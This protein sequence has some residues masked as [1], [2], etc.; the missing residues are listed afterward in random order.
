MRART[1]LPAAAF[2]AALAAVFLTIL[3]LS[4]LAGPFLETG[5]AAPLTWSSL[6]GPAG[7]PALGIA[8]SPTYA[9]DRL[10]LAGGGFDLGRASWAGRGLFRSDDGG[11]TWPSRSG[12]QNG[13]LLDVAFSPAWAT[14]HF[15]LAGYWFGLWSTTDGGATWQQI[16][17]METGG[18]SLVGAVAVSPPTG[19]KRTLLAGSSYGG[20]FRS[21]DNGATWAFTGGP[22]SVRRVAFHP[23]LP[24][25][26]LAATSN[27]LWR[28][29]NAGLTWTAVTTPTQA[30]DI[31][32]R[33]DNGEA[34]ATFSDRLWRSGDGGLTWQRFTSLEARFL[35][36]VAV[37]PEGSGL[38]ASVGSTIFRYDVASSSFVTL[39]AN[40]GG[41]TILRLAISPNYAA[42]GTLFAG[43]PDG[44]WIS[45]DRGDTFVRSPGFYTL[46]VSHLAPS[47]SY[48][49][50]G[51]LFV[52]TEQ[53]V[54]RRTGGAWRPATGGLTGLLA[55]GVT[56]LAI[57][58]DYDNDGTLFASRPT[59][60][61]IGGALY[62]S[63]D[64][65]D[66]WRWIT[67]KAYIGG[68][69]VSPAFA[70]DHRAYMLGESRVFTSTDAGETWTIAP[71]WIYTYTAR[72]LDI[73]PNFAANRTLYAVGSQVY[74]SLDAGDT[75]APA[76]SPPPLQ[77]T[78]AP[79]WQPGHLAVAPDDTLLLAIYRYETAAP[80]G[81]HDQLWRSD[82]GGDVWAQV[83]AVPDLPIAAVTFDASYPAHP[84]I[85]LATFDDNLV[86]DHFLA[87]DL[88][89]SPDDGASW[90]N[91]GPPP[92]G[93]AIKELVAPAGTNDTLLAGAVGV[94][95][96]T[97]GELPTATPDPCR[98]LLRNRSFEYE[99][100]WRIPRTA[101]PAARTMDKASHAYWS[102]RSGITTPADNRRSYSDFSQD[103][104]LPNLPT[105]KL[106]F[107]RWPQGAPGGG[108]QAAALAALQSVQTEEQF[109]QALEAAGGDLQYVLVIAPP[110]GTVRFAYA[111]LA[112]NRAW[113]AEEFD[114]SSYRGQRVRIQFGTYNDGLGA[115]AAQYF[116]NM[117]LRACSG[118]PTPRLWLPDIRSQGPGSIPPV[119]N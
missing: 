109:Y 10:V 110:G 114:L 92:D 118:P 22:S 96:V 59:G 71:V 67:T 60:A 14:D 40:L 29:A 73:S 79:Q 26:A 19:A 6:D 76:T 69:V 87:P 54:W 119:R 57:S 100:D 31:A 30:F 12:P 103:V 88:F 98:E 16:S 37:S 13:A 47:A 74:R 1:T 107:Q 75:W 102:M 33:A 82:D 106:S 3:S 91:V 111:G 117:S 21:A 53:G 11:L 32:F 68:I 89:R 9:Q 52:A 64:R 38:F 4:A 81:R 49:T 65:G 46:T 95:Q 90:Q 61:S 94:W 42:D 7:G 15:A 62:K 70:T 34:Y 44:V 50:G 48:T 85:Y 45:R 27:G 93:A 101:Y 113:V 116:D 108:V 86:D 36:R 80:Y 83:T 18:P 43:T 115:T 51:D 20:V 104:D 39:T 84:T 2:F 55:T 99:G 78:D 112:D 41:G 58:P 35:D 72:L 97:P 8:L 5:R 105:V 66:S 63:T 24:D 56:G 17:S 23:T 25:V 28:T 77:A